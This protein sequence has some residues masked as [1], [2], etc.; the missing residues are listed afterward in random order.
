MMGSKNQTVTQTRTIQFFLQALL[1]FSTCCYLK[2][3]S[4]ARKFR[5][6]GK[7]SASETKVTMVC[8][9][10]IEGHTIAK[11]IPNDLDNSINLLLFVT[12]DWGFQ[13]R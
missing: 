9:G 8:G 7:F 1:D 3:N 4:A 11:F 2:D 13:P 10:I 5:S 12:K 6:S